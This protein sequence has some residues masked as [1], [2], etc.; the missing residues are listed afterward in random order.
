MST[1]VNNIFK[2][3]CFAFLFFTVGILS[4][5]F[6]QDEKWGE[7]EIQSVEIEIVK[8]RLITLPKANRNFE[9]IPPRPAEPI[10]PEITY[11]LKNFNFTSTDYNP[12]IRPLKLKQ[13]ELAKIYG[14]YLSAG[15]G[16]YVSPFLEAYVNSKR[17]KSKF[18]GGHFYHRSFGKGPV[19]GNNSASGNSQLDLFGKFFSKAVTSGVY[20]NYENRS[21]FFYGYPKTGVDIDRGPTK[22]EYNIVGLG[23]E[24]ENTKQSD[25]NFKLKGGF[26][27]LDDRYNAKESE[28]SLNWNNNYVISETSQFIFKADYFLIARKDLLKDATPRNL[29]KVS[30]AYR[31]SPVDKLSLTLGV[32]TAFENDKI[33]SKSFHIY[34][35]VWA[36]YSLGSTVEAYA[37][38][39]GDM[40][41]VSLHTLSAE[42]FWLNANIDIYHTNRAAELMIGLKGKALKKVT[43]DGGFSVATLKNLYFYRNATADAS[44]FNTEYELGD[45][46]RLNLFGDVGI[47]FTQK[48][49]LNFRAD[50][51]SYSR[52]SD[53]EAW[54]RPTYR[55]SGNSYFNIYDKVTLHADLIVQGGMKAFDPIS[56]QILTLNPAVDLSTKVNYF[57][58]RKFSVFLK[59]NNMLSTKYPLYLNYPSRGFQG[60]AGISW[61]F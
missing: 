48:A 5:T 15:F 26:S 2:M 56:L 34:P 16:N 1:V 23:A 51:F 39:T 44:K 9:K 54:H 57:V 19:D 14:N 17:D 47:S 6:A 55:L 49:R 18:Y 40:D 3:K 22:Q 42:N 11:D 52:D 53:L 24:I 13:E 30:P 58:S 36:N 4:Q 35:N 12:A 25:F 21:G 8:D 31:F 32:N 45:T 7:G 37:G 27:Y 60:L 29:L 33:D 46:K 20:V 43:F 50:Y 38:L 28:V 59:F 61:S 41:K 10:R